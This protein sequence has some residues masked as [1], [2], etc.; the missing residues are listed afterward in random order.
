MLEFAV[1]W[2]YPLRKI[3]YAPLL[4]D[5]LLKSYNFLFNHKLLDYIDEIEKEALSWKGDR[6]Y[7]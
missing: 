4:L 2:L 3:P 6:T 5:T 1:R 7:S